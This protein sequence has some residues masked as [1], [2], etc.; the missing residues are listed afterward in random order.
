MKN[1]RVKEY[2]LTE[3]NRW[4]CKVC[5]KQK[6][7]ILVGNVSHLK[8]H[9]HSKHKDIAIELGISERRRVRNNN[10]Y[11]GNGEENAIFVSR[12]KVKFDFNINDTVRDFI[13]SILMRN[14]PMTVADDM[15]KNEM[16]RKAL[17]AFGVRWNRQKAK[18]FILKA[19]EQI[20]EIIAKDIENVYPSL[21]FDSASRFNTNVFSASIRYTKDGK[22]HDRTLGMLTQH[23]R[24]VEWF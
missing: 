19:A 22:L 18:E 15:G 23:G 13:K 9:L 11:E 7:A 6:P 4:K 5:A 8:N 10:H 16:I 21:M 24:Q 20:Y 14:L 12:K 3:N 1:T 17:Q 2:F